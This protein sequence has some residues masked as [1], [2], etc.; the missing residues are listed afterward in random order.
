M[1]YLLAKKPNIGI[2]VLGRVA[3]LG[4]PSAGVTRPGTPWRSHLAQFWIRLP[5]S[6]D[7]IN[8]TT[9]LGFDHLVSLTDVPQATELDQKI[10]A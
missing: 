1:N 8:V 5:L 3:S 10:S 4:R 7:G 9:I 2:E 6:D